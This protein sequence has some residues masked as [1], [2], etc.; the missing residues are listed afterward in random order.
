LAFGR[1]LSRV[2]ARLGG[3]AREPQ[4]HA[5]AS[6]LFLRLLGAIYIIAF[7]SLAVQVRGLIGHAGIAPLGDYLAAARHD[8]GAAAF[9]RMP[10]VFWLA[11]GDAAL[12][13]AT[14]IG[15]LLGLLVACNIAQRAALVGAF[16]R[17]ARGSSS[18]S[19]AFSSSVSS[20]SPA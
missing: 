7:A 12:L 15:A 14:L 16:S 9:W 3:P 19:T 2:S 5:I 13:A 1:G 18:G 10:T 11:S 20:F 4:G 6:W 8:W 17:P